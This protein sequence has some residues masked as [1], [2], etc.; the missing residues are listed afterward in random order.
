MIGFETDTAPMASD[1]MSIG[2]LAVL[3]RAGNESCS[4]QVRE[5]CDRSSHIWNVESIT[6]ESI[7]T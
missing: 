5:A 4:H 1:V 3:N 7:M 6:R 2:P